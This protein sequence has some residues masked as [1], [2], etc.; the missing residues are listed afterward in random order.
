MEL[1]I[2]LLTEEDMEL[3]LE[4]IDPALANSLR[5]AILREVPVMA[6]DELEVKYNDSTLHDEIIAHRLAMLPLRT[7][8]KG[9]SL[10]EECRCGGKGCTECTVTLSLQKE[11]PCLVTS[12]DLRSSDEE[13][14]PVSATVPIVKLEKGQRLELT[15]F[16]RLGRGKEHAKWQA[17][18]ASYKYQPIVRVD[19]GKCDGCGG[20]VE[21]CPPRILTPSDGKVAVREVERCIMCR[22]C[23]KECRRKAIAVSFDDSRFIFRVES[24][25]SL[26][27]EQLFLKAVEVL[28]EKCRK[29]GKLVEKLEGKE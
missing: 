7:P 11:G 1:R 18:I 26:P 12:G 27:P 25:G 9:Y 24:Y 22:A 16:A 17:G 6:V 13:V 3:R 20:C 14:V 5:R 29:F 21:V 4:G 28:Q 15:A 19:T 10:R 8:L 23:E 2:N